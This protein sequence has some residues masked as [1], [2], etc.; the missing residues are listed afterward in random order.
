[1]LKQLVLSLCLLSMTPVSWAISYGDLLPKVIEK[2]P[3]KNQSDAFQSL[4]QANQN[5]ANS[6]IAGDFAVTVRHEN[7]N[8]IGDQSDQSWEFGAAFPIW[9]P[10]QTKSLTQLGETY[11]TLTTLSRKSLRLSASA[12]LRQLVWNYKKAQVQLAFSQQSLTQTQSLIDFISQ[13]VQAGESP[14]F[15]LLVAQ[16][17]MVQYQQITAQHQASF[18]V[19][20]Q[21]FLNWTGETS[22]PF[23]LAETL[24]DTQATHPEREF[25]QSLIAIENAKLQWVENQKSANP[26]VFIGSRLESSNDAASPDKQF[27]I[28]EISIPLGL[29]PASKSRKAEQNQMLTDAKIRQ[30]EI[31][32][33]LQ[34]DVLTA[35]QQL[36]ATENIEKLAQQQFT[37]SEEAMLLAESAYQQGETTIQALLLA[38]QQFFDDQLNNQLARLNRLEAIAKLNQA[39]GVILE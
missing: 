5:Y 6:W 24:A 19:A 16:K 27:L 35:Q 15:D 30:L 39:Q 34:L 17:S 20:Q 38:K 4:A 28:A 7:A 10:G 12:K 8:I 13:K 26:S 21:D 3:K 18:T 32:Q 23:P 9:K 2:L 11:Q 29:D 33:Q 1:M 37:L 22:L 36:L 25:H 14:K 31:N